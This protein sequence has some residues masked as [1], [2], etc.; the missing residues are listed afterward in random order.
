MS[1]VNNPVPSADLPTFQQLEG[2]GVETQT[3]INSEAAETVLE[4]VRSVLKTAQH[5][6]QTVPK[7]DIDFKAVDLSTSGSSSA[8]P[9]AVVNEDTISDSISET[10]D[11]KS[12]D[13]INNAKVDDPAT[14]ASQDADSA[15]S[16]SD[17]P[18][19]SS[20]DNVLHIT[21]WLAATVFLSMGTV[22]GVKLKQMHSEHKASEKNAQL[23]QPNTQAPEKASVFAAKV[24]ASKELKNYARGSLAAGAVCTAATLLRTI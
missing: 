22:F 2:G 12:E 16:H 14:R 17:T 15:S 9:N 3:V 18:E 24:M 5:T 23:S 10:A 7:K 11:P 4:A 20:F 8:D 1:I 21:Q 19:A 6:A 13:L